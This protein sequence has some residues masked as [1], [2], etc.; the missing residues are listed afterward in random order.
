MTLFDIILIGIGLSMDAAAVSMTNGM[1]YG[2][3]K[4]WAMPV[5][6]G[7]FQGLMP[8]LGFIACGLFA[9]LINQYANL[10]V[11]VILGIIGGKMIK[12]G[13]HSDDEWT[14]KVAVLTYQLLLWQA[15]AT[16]IDAFAVGI[17]FGAMG[18]NILY[19]VV[20]IALTT[21]IC[22]WLAI[23]IGK[24]FGDF[25]GSKAEI[26]GGLILVIIGLKALF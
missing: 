2:R 20:I 14:S 16:S 12:D 17:G 8:L 3:Q 23:I 21:F 13:L 5:L 24:K 19:C 6:F 22:S 9:N 25:L 4:T 10:A 26:L 11:C 7:F 18:V 15:L 1:V